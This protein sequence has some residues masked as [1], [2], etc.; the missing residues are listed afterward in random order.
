MAMPRRRTLLLFACALCG[1]DGAMGLSNSDSS[2]DASTWH[3]RPVRSLQARVETDAPLW[4]ATHEV[5]VS[6]HDPNN[7]QLTFEERYRNTLDSVTTSSVE[8]ALMYLQRDCIDVGANPIAAGCKRRN[9]VKVITFME[10][11]I[12]QPFEALSYYQADRY[13][14]PEFCPFVTMRNGQCVEIENDDNDG[15]DEDEDIVANPPNCQLY[16]GLDTSMSSWEIG[17]CVGAH[18]YPT[19]IVAPYPNTVWFS[20]PNSCVMNTWKEGKSDECREKYKGGLCP[21][22]VEPDGVKCS[23]AYKILGYLSID[24]LVGIVKSDWS[25]SSSSGSSSGSAVSTVSTPS[26]SADGENDDGETRRKLATTATEYYN[27]YKDFCEAKQI[28]LHAFDTDDTLGLKNVT[29]ISFWKNPNVQRLCGERT[30]ERWEPDAAAADEFDGADERQS[31]VLPEREV[32]L[33]FQVWVRAPLVRAGL[34]RVSRAARELR[35]ESAVVQLPDHEG[36][37]DCEHVELIIFIVIGEH[38]VSGK[39]RGINVKE[40]T[41]E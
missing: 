19:D 11:T 10:I 17:P 27:D 13:I 9:D 36:G 22:G 29:A 34:Q 8:G 31:A 35:R 30:S 32:V 23:F 37:A 21:F 12:A 20:Y 40:V 39:R 4:D 15:E 25:S 28:E 33:R 18:A 3:M 5:F 1:R 41:T 24:E 16:N 6:G 26:S 38:E 14:Y 7:S 2:T